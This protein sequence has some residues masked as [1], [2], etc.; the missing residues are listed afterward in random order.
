MNKKKIHHHS[1]LGNSPSYSETYYHSYNSRQ[2][3]IPY[4]NTGKICIIE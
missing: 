4:S 1:T 3:I 2:V